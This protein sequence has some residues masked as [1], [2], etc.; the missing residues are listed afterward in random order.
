MH[1]SQVGITRLIPI[2]KNDLDVST[3]AFCSFKRED[4]FANTKDKVFFS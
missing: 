2:T 1:L 4:H 3:E